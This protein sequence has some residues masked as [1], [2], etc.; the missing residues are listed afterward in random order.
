MPWTMQAALETQQERAELLERYKESATGIEIF[1][2]LQRVHRA[3]G[4]LQ[5]M[6]GGLKNSRCCR[7]FKAGQSHRGGG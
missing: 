2:M 7:G 6:Q 5:L 4:I 3:L 1:G